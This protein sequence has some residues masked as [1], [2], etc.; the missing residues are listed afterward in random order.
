MSFRARIGVAG[1]FLRT[2]DHLMSE[3]TSDAKKSALIAA[4][5]QLKE[6]DPPV[7]VAEQVDSMIEEIGSTLRRASRPD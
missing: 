2:T 7:F 3:R 4:L 5:R 6:L 1:S